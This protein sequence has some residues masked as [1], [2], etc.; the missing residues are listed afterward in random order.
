MGATI[1]LTAIGVASFLLVMAV[2]VV[3]TPWRT[4]STSRRKTRFVGEMLVGHSDSDTPDMKGV[5]RWFGSFPAGVP[6]GS[7]SESQS[8]PR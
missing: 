3:A 5:R 6:R 2:E 8:R 4:R 7:R 1:L